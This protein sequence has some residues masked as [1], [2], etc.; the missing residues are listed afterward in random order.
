MDQ[1]HN[2]THIDQRN[3]FVSNLGSHHLVVPQAQVQ[4]LEL[5]LEPEQV[6]EQALEPEQ[7]LEP[8]LAWA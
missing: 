6:L 7:V 4:V 1:S 8:A 3:N 5:L 2:L